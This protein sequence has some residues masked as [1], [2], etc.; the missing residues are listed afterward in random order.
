MRAVAVIALLAGCAESHAE[1]APGP[2]PVARPDACVL[3]A[4]G[5]LSSALAAAKDGDALCLATGVHS[6]PVRI[7]RRVSLW[8]PRDAVIR[9]GR[10]G[11]V[12]TI[13]GAGA[14]LSGLTVDGTGGRFDTLDAA[15]HV[16]ADD[17]TVEGV[18]VVHAV[19]GILVEKTRRV[20]VRG[21][22]VAG[23][24]GKAMGVRGDTIRLWE[25]HDSIV[26]DNLVED[27][28]DMVVWYSRG[29]RVARNQVLRGRYGTHFMYSDDNVVED[30]RYIDGVVGV[31][32]MYS[33]GVELRRNVIAG[34][35]GA[36]G[37][38]IGLKD[39]GN[40]VVEH[41]V[42]VRDQTGV[43][44][45]QSP[46]RAG[47]TL[48]VRGNV[49]RQCDTAIAFHTT[50]ARTEITGND[51]ADNL[52]QIHAEAGIDPG[53]AAWRGNHYGDYTGYDLDG[54]GTGDVPYEARSASEE[55]VASHPNLAFFRGGA[56][57][58]VVDAASKLLPLWRPRTLLVDPEPRM[59]G[60]EIAE[61]LDAR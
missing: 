28:R 54:D 38:A 49:I 59:R 18:S 55:L 50:P 20:T 2:G 60:R 35:G 25:T 39:S 14:R 45:D 5:E 43:F 13:A 61:V 51:L 42:L 52:R 1:V 26:E 36:A 56:V 8:G 29:N 6:G 47:D 15:I 24:A 23:D 32:V 41:N 12:V 57:L 27:G 53:Q 16:V 37:L 58:G 11:S 44:I 21:N 46:G 30:N 19:Y 4:A 10:S 33:R 7:E 3:V 40:L 9:S 34:A 22:H 31:F 48:A 17:V